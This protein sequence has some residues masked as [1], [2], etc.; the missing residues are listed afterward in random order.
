[1]IKLLSTIV[2]LLAAGSAMAADTPA[3]LPAVAPPAVAP[4][5]VAPTAAAPSVAPAEAAPA[6]P[7]VVT[8][9]KDL[10]TPWSGEKI[11]CT[12]EAPMGS[13]IP[14]RRCTTK[15]NDDQNERNA[16]ELLSRPIASGGPQ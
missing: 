11:V 7:I 14:V 8:G 1:M 15:S 10:R 5:T 12:R 9:N 6:K 3:A 16:R 13:L 4:P 2:V